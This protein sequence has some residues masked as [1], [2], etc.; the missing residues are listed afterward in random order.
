V[1]AEAGT[2]QRGT[3]IASPNLALPNKVG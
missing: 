1:S 2:P 3:Q